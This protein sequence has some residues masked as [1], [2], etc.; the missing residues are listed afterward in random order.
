MNYMNNNLEYG[1]HR[2]SY[3]SCHSRWD[4]SNELEISANSEPLARI[5]PKF[6]TSLRNLRSN[7]NEC[8]IFYLTWIRYVLISLQWSAK[9]Y[10]KNHH[11]PE[12]LTC[13]ANASERDHT[14]FDCDALHCKILIWTHEQS[15][16][17]LP[18]KRLCFWFLCVNL[19]VIVVGYRPWRMKFILHSKTTYSTRFTWKTM[20]DNSVVKSLKRR[21]L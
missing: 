17:A 2:G 21:Y 16:L 19:Q 1:K 10:N 3:T 20:W 15:V 4:F 9:I 6:P 5:L 11:I 8:K 13:F 14:V 18:K 12:W 7:D